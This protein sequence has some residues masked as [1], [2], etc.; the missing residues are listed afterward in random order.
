MQTHTHVVRSADGPHLPL[1][2][3]RI[4][5]RQRPAPSQAPTIS[6]AWVILAANQT[7]VRASPMA[8]PALADDNALRAT[9]KFVEPIESHA[10]DSNACRA[11]S[12]LVGRWRD[13]G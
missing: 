6:R 2:S 9:V 1:R 10:V 3:K 11:M 7:P 5:E 8:G 13:L 4:G 12:R